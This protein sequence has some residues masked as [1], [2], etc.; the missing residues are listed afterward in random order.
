MHCFTRHASDYL[1]TTLKRTISWNTRLTMSF[2]IQVRN[3]APAGHVVLDGVRVLAFGAIEL[4][5]RRERPG[6]WIAPGLRGSAM[7]IRACGSEGRQTLG[8]VTPKL[9]PSDSQGFRRP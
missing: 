9:N 7:G 6:K 4:G 5:R 1:R 3:S 2:S 8:L